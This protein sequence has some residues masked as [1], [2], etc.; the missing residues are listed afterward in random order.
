MPAFLLV[1][2]F[3]CLPLWTHC[4]VCEEDDLKAGS[5]PNAGSCLWVLQ[6][7]NT[8]CVFEMSRSKRPLNGAAASG[9]VSPDPS[10]NCFFYSRTE[11]SGPQLLFN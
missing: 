2:V 4:D 3:G 10:Q 5:F 6:L 11:T 7:H 9:G 8:R 1:L